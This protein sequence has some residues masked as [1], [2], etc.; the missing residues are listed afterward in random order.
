MLTEITLGQYYPGSS[1][2]HHLDPRTKI[3]GVLFYM[4]MVFLASDPL[5]YGL[6]IAFWSLPRVLLNC[7]LVFC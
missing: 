5:G 1:P 2:I 4:V 3:L 6:L 7:R